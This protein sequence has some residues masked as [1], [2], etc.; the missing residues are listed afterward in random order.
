MAS[1]SEKSYC[2]C[3]LKYLK[4][5]CKLHSPRLQLNRTEFKTRK[6]P[7]PQARKGA[8]VLCSQKP[9]C[10]SQRLFCHCWLKVFLPTQCKYLPLAMGYPS[11]KDGFDP[12]S[13]KQPTTHIDTRMDSQS[14]SVVLLQGLSSLPGEETVKCMLLLPLIIILNIRWVL[15]RFGISPK[16]LTHMVSVYAHKTHTR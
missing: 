2:Y 12:P 14:L 15:T 6:L 4:P 7:I 10:F 9:N 13:F 3:I 11:T 16:Q 8:N 1:K 5:C